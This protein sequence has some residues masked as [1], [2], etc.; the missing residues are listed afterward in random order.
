MPNRSEYQLG[1]K[2]ESRRNGLLEKKAKRV[3]FSQN[4]SAASLELI[5]I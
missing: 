2:F 1:S 4:L 5:S 3:G